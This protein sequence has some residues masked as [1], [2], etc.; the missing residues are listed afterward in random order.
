MA[1]QTLPD[2]DLDFRSLSDDAWYSVRLVVEGKAALRVMYCNFSSDLDEMYHGDGFAALREVEDFKTRFRVPS[3][4]LQDEDCWRVNKGTVVCASH[5]FGETDVRFYDAIVD[6]VMRSGHVN[7]DGESICR[8]TFMVR[9]Q[10]GPLTGETTPTTVQDICLVQSRS[11]QNLTLDKFLEFSRK[12]FAIRSKPTNVQT[13][14]RNKE[15]IL[16]VSNAKDTK[17]TSHQ[18]SGLEMRFPNVE[19][20][21][22]KPINPEANCLGLWIDNLE[23]DLCPDI[24]TDFIYEHTSIHV[25]LELSQSIIPAMCH[26]GVV[27]VKTEKQAKRLIDF[28]LDSAHIV[29]SSKGRPW[30]FKEDWRQMCKGTVPRHEQHKPV[31]NKGQQD[32]S[33]LRLTHRGTKEYER[34]KELQNLHSQYH[35]HVERLYLKLQSEERKLMLRRG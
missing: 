32:D 28:L 9:W 7:V 8:C 19:E 12:R 5:T 1:G 11:P 21:L 2:T 15:P 14:K 22:A 25:Q 18:S 17:G 30:F 6:S 29:I 35:N 33:R 27:T 16:D 26:G 20:P 23:K 3:T 34:A 10:H 4:Q 24:M 31:Q 13:I